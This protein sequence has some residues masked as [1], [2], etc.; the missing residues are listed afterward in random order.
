MI[1]NYCSALWRSFAPSVGNHLWQSTLFALVAALLAF[2]LR[3]NSARTRYWLW[4]SASVKFLFPFSLLVG[5]GSHLAWSQ[6]SAGTKT[7]LYVAMT[8]VGQ[9]FAQP[10]TPMYSQAARLTLSASLIHFLPAFLTTLWLCGFM[11]AL[12]LWYVRW[13]RISALVREAVPL[14]EGREVDTLRRVERTQ[15]I[16]KPIQMRLSRTSLEPGIFG[17]IR[18]VLVWPQGIS[19]RLEDPHLES[20]LAHELLHVRRRDNL[21]A[22]VHT[23]VEAIFWFYPLVWWLGARLLEERE[24]VCDEAVLESGSDRQVYAESI[25][26]I[27]EFCVG[28]PLAC[29]SGVTGADLKKRMAYIMTKNLSRKLDFSRKLLLS[30]AGLSAVAAPIVFGLLHATQTRA[31]SQAQITT[32]TVPSFETALI[33]PSNGEPMAG[34]EIVGKPFTGIM[35][36]GDRLMATNFTLH[37]LIRVAYAIQDDQISG[38]PDWLNSEGY[39]IDAKI[40]KSVVDDMQKRGPVYGVSGRTRMFQELLSDR[41]KLSFHRE[42]KDLPVYGL[43]IAANGPKVRPAKPGDTYLNGL[44]CFGGRPCGAGVILT[45]EAGKLVGQGVPIASLVQ[46]LSEHYVHRAVLDKTGLTDKYDF[47]LQWTPEE[48]Q[49]AIFAAIQEQ[50]GLKLQPQKA[51][52]EVLVIDH[53]EKP[54]EPQAQSTAPIVPV[55]ETVSITPSKSGGHGDILMFGP[56]RFTS[57]NASLQQL[58]RE[59]YGVEDDRIS[60]APVWLESEKYDVE[61]KEYSR[62]DDARNVGLNQR[63]SEQKSMLQAMLAE[64]LKL[65]VHR[66][67]RDLTVYALVIATSGP[68]LQESKPGETYPKLFKAPDGVPRPGG[69]HFDGQRLIAQAVPLQAIQF[70]LSRQLHRTILDETGLSGT[71]DFALHLPDGILPGIDNPAPPDSYEPA[72]STAIEQQLGLKLEPRKASMEILVIEHIEKPSEN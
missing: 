52:M 61:A 39:D 12:C 40:G 33:K 60:G 49:P 36:K 69:I 6:G 46:D 43:V 8:N 4:L 35:W 64:R 68:K 62:A 11:M 9:P 70:H 56:D 42:T 24:R 45:P 71:Y 22:A 34:F 32:P 55:Y 17:I 72:V 50:L 54:S 63:V 29:V 30:V 10:T 58:I 20:I 48:S 57:S 23:L 16:Q 38:G 53:A 26:K 51:P 19:G 31:Q 41:F 7:G 25:L 21:A 59:A 14:L 1:L 18:P 15:D 47:T 66:E 5:I 37:G 67:T 13:R 2:V 44:T 3:R 28:S 65:A 27:C